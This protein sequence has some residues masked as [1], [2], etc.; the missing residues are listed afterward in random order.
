MLYDMTGGKPILLSENSYQK[1]KDLQHYVEKNMETLLG[2]R[3]MA[4][5]QRLDEN[6]RADSIAYDESTNALV[7]VEYK[8]V[9]NSGIVDQGFNYLAVMLENRGNLLHD[10]RKQFKSEKEMNDVDWTQSRIIFIALEFSSRQIH[11][12]SFTDMPFEL[13]EAKRYNNILSLKNVTNKMKNCS[14]KTFKM[15]GQ[16]KKVMDEVVIYSEED[17]FRGHEAFYEIFCDL[18]DRILELDR[19]TYKVKKTG[20]SFEVDG[21]RFC[22]VNCPIHNKDFDLLL[23]NEKQPIDDPY[24]M[25]TNIKSHWGNLTWRVK[26]NLQSDLDQ[27]MSYVEQAYQATDSSKKSTAS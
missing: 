4:T 22:E 15:E 26:V 10:L 2:L 16:Y 20:M 25:A 27:I 23:N 3:F 12:T 11:A 8:K 5:E 17:H 9:E 24:K 13:W 14:V 1:E 19:T 21:K 7:I 6:N 18:K